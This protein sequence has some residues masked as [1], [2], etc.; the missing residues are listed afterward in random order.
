MKHT[1]KKFFLSY[2]QEAI[3]ELKDIAGC[4]SKLRN[5]LQTSKSLIP[6]EDNRS[7]AKA[8]NDYL[9]EVTDRDGEEPSWFIS[10]WLYVECYMYRRVQEAVEKRQVK[11]VSFNYINRPKYATFCIVV[12]TAF[13]VDNFQKKI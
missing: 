11:I 7:D 10:P 8:W 5:E 3:E 4:V 1:H 9:R 13:K 12:F 6:V 2:I